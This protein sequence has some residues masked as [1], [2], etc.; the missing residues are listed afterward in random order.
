MKKHLIQILLIIIVLIVIVYI[1]YLG[2]MHSKDEIFSNFGNFFGGVIGSLVALI[3]LVFAYQSYSKQLKQTFE[4]NSIDNINKM[5]NELTA[6]I[7][8]IEYKKIRG[9]EAL[10][11]FDQDHWDEPNSVMNHLILIFSSFETLILTIKNG[12][13]ICVGTK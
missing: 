9:V 2:I 4:S 1:T 5:L 3:A 10:Y 8:R 6:D 7:D 12:N 11:K 13:Y